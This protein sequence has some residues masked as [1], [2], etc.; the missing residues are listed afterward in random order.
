M[1]QPSARIHTVN[2][3]YFSHGDAKNLKHPTVILNDR[4]KLPEKREHG[5]KV[6]QCPSSEKFAFHFIGFI[7]LTTLLLSGDL[8]IFFM[9]MFLLLLVGLQVGVL[10]IGMVPSSKVP[11]TSIGGCVQV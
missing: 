11:P 9:L 8:V 1:D 4:K 10:S 6:C 7:A 5:R 3:L 2:A